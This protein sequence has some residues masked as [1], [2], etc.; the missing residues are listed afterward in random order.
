MI[1]DAHAHLWNPQAG[2]VDGNPVI[3]ITGERTRCVRTM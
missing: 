1:I 3:P 2:R